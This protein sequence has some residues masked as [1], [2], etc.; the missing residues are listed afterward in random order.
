MNA[1]NDN[2]LKDIFSGLRRQDAARVPSFN[3][4]VRA[5]TRA[6]EVEPGFAFSWLRPAAAAVV[7]MAA[8]F[9][10]TTFQ[11]HQTTPAADT[12]QWAALTEWSAST[13]GLLT[14]SAAVWSSNISTV[15]DSWIQDSESFSSNQTQQEQAL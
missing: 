10:L 9:L 15:T 7:L 14:S 8:I 12:E 2:K 3:R 5:A 11:K 4:V 13:D 1:D 6:R